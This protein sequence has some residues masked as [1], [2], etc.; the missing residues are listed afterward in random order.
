MDQQLALRDPSI[1]RMRNNRW[2][3]AHSMD[4]QTALRD[5][6]IAQIDRTPSYFLI[7]VYKAIMKTKI[8][9]WAVLINWKM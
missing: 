8:I 5:R 2:I 3:F 6:P 7:T 4:P 9:K 1:D